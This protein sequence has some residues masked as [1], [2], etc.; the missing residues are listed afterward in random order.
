MSFTR[1]EDDAELLALGYEQGPDGNYYPANDPRLKALK[2]AEKNQAPVTTAVNIRVR[3]SRP[4]PVDKQSKNNDS[5]RKNAT[6]KKRKSKSRLSLC[7]ENETGKRWRIRV[8]NFRVADFDSDNLYPKHY[9]DELV[10]RGV[11]PD[12]SSKYV[13]CT[14]KWIVPVTTKEEERTLVE[15]YEYDYRE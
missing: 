12:D 14:S 4:L 8:T 6:G 15:V 13:D 7:R 3:D 1:L 5:K 9:I 11:I 2:Q 10:K